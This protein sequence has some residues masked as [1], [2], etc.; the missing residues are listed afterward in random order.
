MAV[1]YQVVMT[2]V[3]DWA[4]SS[5]RT[6]ATLLDGNFGADFVKAHLCEGLQV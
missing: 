5:E 6:T 4:V 3:H 2:L 1:R